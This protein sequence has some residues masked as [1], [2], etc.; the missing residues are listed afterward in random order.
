MK[1]S[2]SSYSFQQYIGTGRMSHFDT[3][4]KA[5]EMGFEAIEFLDMPRPTYEERRQMPAA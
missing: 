3:I 2:V 4:R 5:Q 1:I